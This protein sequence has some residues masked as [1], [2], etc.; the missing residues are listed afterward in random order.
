MPTRIR[1]ACREN[2]EPEPADEGTLIRAILDSLALRYDQL[3]RT[4]AQLTGRTIKTL[5]IVGGGGANT[6]L[7]DASNDGETYST[8]AGRTLRYRISDPR[9]AEVVALTALVDRG[10]GDRLEA[11]FES[12]LKVTPP[13]WEANHCPLCE[14]GDAVIKPGGAL[15][16]G[17]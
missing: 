4:A 7:G 16:K 2:G 11:R 5:H 6:T 9:G 15:R 14:A 10:G 1:E 13:T 12:L 17:L 8:P 3:I